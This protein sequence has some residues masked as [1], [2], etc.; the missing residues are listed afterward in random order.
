MTQSYTQNMTWYLKQRLSLV[1]GWFLQ[2]PGLK[3]SSPEVVLELNLKTKRL[4]G[5]VVL[6]SRQPFNQYMV[7]V[8]LISR[9]QSQMT[10][11]S[12]TMTNIYFYNNLGCVQRTSL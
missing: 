11:M 7:L 1:L 4:R 5:S 12:Y 8:L 2:L 3:A 6:E 10:P 9:L